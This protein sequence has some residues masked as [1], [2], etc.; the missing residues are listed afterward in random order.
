MIG[1]GGAWVGLVTLPRYLRRRL[2]RR[3]EP[4][5]GRHLQ[6]PAPSPRSR[7]ATE[8]RGA[9]A[10]A[11]VVGTP[12]GSA[13]CVRRAR[14]RPSPAR[15]A[16]VRPDDICIERTWTATGMC[17]T[18]SHHFRIDGVTVAA[19]RT[20]VPLAGEPC[21]DEPI[22]R[23][24]TPSFVALVVSSVALGIARGALTDVIALAADKV[25]LLD[26]PRRSRPI[27]CSSGR[28]RSS[29]PSC[30]SR[31]LVHETACECG[32]RPSTVSRSPSST[33]QAPPR[34]WQGDR[35]RHPRRRRRPPL[36][37]RHRGLRRLGPP[38]AWPRHPPRPA[39]HRPPRH[40]TAAGRS[41]DANRPS[42]CSAGR[43]RG[44]PTRAPSS[45]PMHH[46]C[47]A[48]VPEGS[49]QVPPVGAVRPEGRRRPA[50][51]A[52]EAGPL[53]EGRDTTPSRRVK[54]SRSPSVAAS[55]AASTRWL[56]GM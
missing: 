50:R 17:A 23:M 11:A 20:F 54:G 30:A 18:A 19:D 24:P 8:S 14:R 48:R 25:P 2:R 38:T 44:A 15:G 26:A 27:P 52:L 40:L 5:R 3:A 49:D 32:P 33:G 56:R 28:S 9:G 29:T 1:G 34:P 31:S 55:R 4:H 22:A 16:L 35:A 21:I 51:R 7:T 53:V 45:G 42:R 37:R 46:H 12:A 39:L 41:S 10:S 47:V 36:R 13:N 43:P 6:Q